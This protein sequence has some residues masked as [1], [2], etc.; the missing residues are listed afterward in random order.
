ML[1]V[2]ASC[3]CVCVCVFHCPF[4]QHWLLARYNFKDVYDVVFPV[5]CLLVCVCSCTYGMCV[6]M[7]VVVALCCHVTLLCLCLCFCCVYVVDLVGSRRLQSYMFCSLH[8]FALVIQYCVFLFVSVC[9]LQYIVI[10]CTYVCYLLVY[11]DTCIMPFV[12]SMCVR[13]H[14][15][16]CCI[17]VWW[18]LYLFGLLP[19]GS[20]VAFGSWFRAALGSQNVSGSSD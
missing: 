4:L 16:C 10:R 5:W 6:Y 7:F 8:P 18:V 17:F 9:L 13:T 12:L 3:S 19:A 15:M 11:M 2:C 14:F 20:A 1:C